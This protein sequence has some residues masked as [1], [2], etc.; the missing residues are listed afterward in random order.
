METTSLVATMEEVVA[1]VGALVSYAALPGTRP[2]SVL[3]QVKASVP[4]PK[5]IVV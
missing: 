5:E 4:L 1:M 2:S 3:R